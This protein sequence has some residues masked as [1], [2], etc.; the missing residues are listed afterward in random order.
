MGQMNLMYTRIGHTT[1]YQGMKLEVVASGRTGCHGCVFKSDE[2]AKSCMH[3]SS[4]VSSERPDKE[5]V[6]FVKVE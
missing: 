3:L 2:G 1:S 4:C 6:K 5:S